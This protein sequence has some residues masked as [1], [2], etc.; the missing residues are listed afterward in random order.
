MPLGREFF[1]RNFPKRVSIEEQKRR[2][3][4]ALKQ[5]IQRL[6]EG[7]DLGARGFPEVSDPFMSF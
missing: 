7:Q 3:P 6:T 1:H 2:G 4:V 5:K